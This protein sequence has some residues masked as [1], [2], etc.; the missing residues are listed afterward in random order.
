MQKHVNSNVNSHTRSSSLHTSLRK[1]QSDDGLNYYVFLF[2][3]K[4]GVSMGFSI[5]S[6]LLGGIIIIC[7]SISWAGAIT[8]II[9][10]LGIIEFAIGIWAAVCLCM[11][12]PC[13]CCYGNPPQ[14][15]SYPRVTYQGFQLYKLCCLTKTHREHTNKQ[16]LMYFFS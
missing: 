2:N 11:M 8:A 1:C 13:T 12:K 15:V 5:T 4:V 14:Q 10:V 16:N 3:S 9:L 7:Y 6:S